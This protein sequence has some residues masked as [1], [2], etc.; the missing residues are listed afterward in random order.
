MAGPW[1]KYSPAWAYETQF[2]EEIDKRDV[3]NAMS[4]QWETGQLLPIKKNR[5][6]GDY[7]WAVPQVLSAIIDRIMTP[8]RALQ[9]DHSMIIASHTT[10]QST[11]RACRL[12]ESPWGLRHPNEIPLDLTNRLLSS[13][14][15]PVK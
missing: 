3:Y 1:E 2:A 5:L 7:D 11:P 13:G 6:T 10:L 4:D 12:S 14:K 9:G 15:V 8:G